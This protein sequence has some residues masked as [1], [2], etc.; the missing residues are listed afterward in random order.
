MNPLIVSLCALYSALVA[1][2]DPAEISKCNIRIVPTPTQKEAIYHYIEPPSHE[3]TD[4]FIK[5]IGYKGDLESIIKTFTDHMY[6][7][8]RTF[9]AIN[10]KCLSGKTSRFDQIKLPRA[11]I[12]WG[13][14]YKKDPNISLELSK[15]ISKTEAKEQ[16]ATRLVHETHERIVIEKST[17]TR[18][19]IGVVFKDT[20]TVLKKKPVD[21]YQKLKGLSGGAGLI[22]EVPDEPKVNSTAT[23]VSK[24]SWGNDSD[25]KKSDEEEVP[26]IYSDDEEKDDNDDDQSI[27]IEYTDDE[28]ETVFEI[29]D[30]D[31]SF[32]Q[33]DD[34]GN[35]N[36]Q[37]D[38]EAALKAN[39]FK[40]PQRAPTPDPNGLKANHFSAFVMNH[41]KISKLTKADLVGPVYNLLKG[42]YKSCIELEYNM[43]ECYR[44]LSDQLDWN[45]P[46]G[47]R[48]KLKRKRL[49]RSDE[50]YKF[51]D[52][53]LTLVCNTLDQMLKNLRLGYNKAMQRMK[54]TA[55]YQK[56]THIM[57]KDINQQLLHRR[58]M[59]RFEKFVGGRVMG[60]TT[61]YCSGQYDS[62]IFYSTHPVMSHKTKL[63]N[64][65]ISSVD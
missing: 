2:D 39:W 18:K 11:K 24:E 12:L 23:D 14:Y 48:Y 16:E 22:P 57:I 65:Y 38:V 51:S 20:L 3:E 34:M 36:E 13:M 15:P 53:T 64:M 35:T 1:Q 62:V 29:A 31:I 9:A 19:Q 32:N 46:E 44:A 47:N 10:N 61:G 25:T 59:R 60:L 7:P 37:P 42:T 40:K 6:Q 54:W 26:W 49:M 30:T 17:G 28:Q 58:I 27:D 56:R 63:M 33:R 52:G 55:T 21:Q 41:L 4:S 43:E 50:V 45:K 8:W 5:E